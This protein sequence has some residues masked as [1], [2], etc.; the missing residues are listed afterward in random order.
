M[1]WEAFLLMI[2]LKAS[3]FCKYEPSQ[4]RVVKC[5][6]YITDCMLD[7]EKFRFCSRD[8]LRNGNE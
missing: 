4:A 6:E 1:S 3:N 8:Y 7:G 5:E 2:H